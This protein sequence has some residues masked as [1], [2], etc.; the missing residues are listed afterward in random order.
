MN[1]NKEMDLRELADWMGSEASASDAE[2]MA[3]LLV[4]SGYA[5]VSLIPLGF[6]SDCLEKSAEVRHSAGFA[7]RGSD[8]LAFVR[9]ATFWPNI[10]QGETYAEDVVV[11]INGCVYEQGDIEPETITDQSVVTIVSGQVFS[12]MTPLHS[13]LDHFV[14]WQAAQEK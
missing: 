13:M 4:S 7:I 8:Y 11:V 14:A 10:H 5:D 3:A 12:F 6:W 2:I 9:D 1:I